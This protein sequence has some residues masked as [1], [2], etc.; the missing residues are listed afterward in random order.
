MFDYAKEV[1]VD[2]HVGVFVD[3][4]FET[5]EK[6]GVIIKGERFEADLLIAAVRFR[7]VALL[8]LGWREE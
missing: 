3:E 7:P 1:G 4:Y 2:C 6:A 5:E 8:T